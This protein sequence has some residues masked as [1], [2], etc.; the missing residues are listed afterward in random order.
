MIKSTNSGVTNVNGVIIN[1]N[2]VCSIAHLRAIIHK[3]VEEIILKVEC[4]NSD[5]WDSPP[6]TWAQ[7]HQLF[8]KAFK[9]NML[10][11]RIK[12]LLPFKRF[13]KCLTRIILVRFS[14]HLTKKILLY[15]QLL[16]CLQDE[17]IDE[18]LKT[19][20]SAY[21]IANDSSSEKI[22]KEAKLIIMTVFDENKD[23]QISQKELETGMLT[24]LQ[25]TSENMTVANAVEKLKKIQ[26]AKEKNFFTCTI[27]GT[28]PEQIYFYNNSIFR[29]QRRSHWLL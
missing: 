25:M 17:E 7:K 11:T 4:C 26:V 18:F 16:G 21:D 13:L 24:L 6:E 27:K 14:R 2:I 3:W 1:C 12:P 8:S 5:T 15:K 22:V 28:V 23:G 9:K 29:L 20:M 10:S 19:F